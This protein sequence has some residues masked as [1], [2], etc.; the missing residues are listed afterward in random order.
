MTQLH[1]DGAS[2]AHGCVMQEACKLLGIGK[3]KSSRLHPQGDG[4]AEAMVKQVK[5]CIQKEVDS[6]GRDWDLQLQSAVYAIRS[7]PNN[8]TK[9]TP[10]ELIFVQNCLSQ[11]NSLLLHHL[12]SCNNRQRHIM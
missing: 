6:H 1:S 8:N 4:L 7:N 11:P 10:S 2:N 3:S 9:V 12:R 5:S